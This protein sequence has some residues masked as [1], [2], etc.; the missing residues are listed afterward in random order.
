MRKSIWHVV[1]LLL[2][3]KENNSVIATNFIFHLNIVNAEYI[4]C[5]MKKFIFK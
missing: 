4:L 1:F 3:F 2:I 5:L